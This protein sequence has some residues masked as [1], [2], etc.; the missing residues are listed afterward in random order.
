MFVWDSYFSCLAV[1]HFRSLSFSSPSCLVYTCICILYA[2]LLIL[3]VHTCHKL[4]TEMCEI[5]HFFKGD[6]M[7]FCEV[8]TKF[9]LELP[10][11][12]Q[13]LLFKCKK[14]VINTTMCDLCLFLRKMCCKIV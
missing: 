2:L 12:S 14:F 5:K 3:P 7:K 10:Q 8:F 11:N 4:W 9:T 6:L 1:S 13:K